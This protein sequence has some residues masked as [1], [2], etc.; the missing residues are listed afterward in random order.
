[1]FRPLSQGLLQIDLYPKVFLKSFE[2]DLGIEVETSDQ[3]QLAGVCECV[4]CQSKMS[5]GISDG[6][7][8]LM[9]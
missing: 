8:Q 2:E 6:N 7:K 5:H 1:M 3:N 4:D 9:S